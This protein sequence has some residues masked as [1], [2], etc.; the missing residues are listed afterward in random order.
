MVVVCASSHFRTMVESP[1]TSLD[2]T[3]RPAPMVMLSSHCVIF[4][5][6]LVLFCSSTLCYLCVCGD[7]CRVTNRRTNS[8][9]KCNPHLPVAFYEWPVKIPENVPS[10][11]ESG[12]HPHLLLFHFILI[13]YPYL[14]HLYLSLKSNLGH[15]HDPQ[16]QGRRQKKK[17]N[18][19][20]K[21]S[22]LFPSLFV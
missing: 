4:V 7:E 17:D 5:A 6:A 2:P 3:P 11:T 22:R 8:M 19:T 12:K 21:S 18:S 9:Y 14:P 15:E 1:S 16:G 20:K 13:V 10:C